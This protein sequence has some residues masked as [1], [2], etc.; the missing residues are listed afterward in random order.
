MKFILDTN[1]CIY[2]IKQKPSGVIERFKQAEISR[3]GISSITLSELLYGVSKSSK[4]EQNQIALTQFV[5]PLEIS[6][7]GNEAAQYYGDLR[8]QLEKQ[9]TPIGSLD[10]L[11]A[12]VYASY[13]VPNSGK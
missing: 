10:M 6:S 1:I 9:S 11:I 5:A 13:Y 2:I 7:Y 4:P 12:G 3:I 8:A